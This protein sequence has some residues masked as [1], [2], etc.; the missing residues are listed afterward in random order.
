MLCVMALCI[1]NAARAQ[2]ASD[3]I[4]AEIKPRLAALSPD[5]PR[6][7]FELGEEVVDI[8][9][10][11]ETQ[12][13]ARTLLVLAFELDREAGY[14]HG[15]AAS[16][17]M[18]LADQARLTSDARWLGAMAASIDPRYAVPAWDA[19]SAAG[20]RDLPLAAAAQVLPLTRS[21]RGVDARRL[22]ERPDVR[23]VMARY[24]PLFRS[25]GGLS[26]LELDARQWPCPECGNTRS[27]TRM[28]A[29]EPRIVLCY[30]CGGTPGP[31]VSTIML[32][33]HLRVESILLGGEQRA[34]SAQYAL[35]R[36]AP[37]RDPRAEDLAASLGVDPTRTLWRDG[38]WVAPEGGEP[39]PDAE[40][41]P[42]PADAPDPADAA[43]DPDAQPK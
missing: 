29:G 35:D 1:A 30:T 14:R 9:D 3:P 32:V 12:R 28:I 43:G 21:G 27:T 13:L 38:A 36:G 4:P 34:W 26:K 41:S 37:L 20:G 8:V 40:A 33:E 25:V 24:E 23:T 15:V 17:C 5:D 31:D 10:S 22:L 7:Y 19:T 42:E 39:E 11:P 2:D 16:A 6:A 18:A